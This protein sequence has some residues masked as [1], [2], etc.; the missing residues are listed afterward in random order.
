MTKRGLHTIRHRPQFSQMCV[1]MENKAKKVFRSNQ[2]TA[3]SGEHNSQKSFSRNTHK[4]D[5]SLPT[6][7][8]HFARISSIRSFFVIVCESFVASYIL[9]GLIHQLPVRQ[10]QAQPSMPHC[11]HSV[12]AQVCSSA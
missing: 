6:H 3:Y 2:K 7:Y 5:K 4:S 9:P 10:S 12:D 11:M 8:S 1:A